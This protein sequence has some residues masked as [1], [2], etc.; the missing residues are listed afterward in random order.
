MSTDLIDELFAADDDKYYPGSRRER[1]AAPPP[2]PPKAE[3][4][5]DAKPIRKRLRN[6]REIEFFEIGDLAAALGRPVVTIRRWERLGYIP[7][8][9]YRSRPVLVQGERRQGNRLYSRAIVEATVSAFGSRGLMGKQRL[10]WGALNDLSIGL[11]EEWKR[12]KNSETT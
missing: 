11:F 2:P 3:D 10:E 12:I 4:E 7:T 5:W 8:A 9:P 1:R 6:G